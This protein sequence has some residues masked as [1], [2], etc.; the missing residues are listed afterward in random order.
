MPGAKDTDVPSAH[1][2]MVNKRLMS[3]D[4]QHCAQYWTLGSSWG[5]SGVLTPLCPEAA[6]Q[7]CPLWLP[8]HERLQKSL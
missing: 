8:V 4:L 7:C 5:E 1:W 6:L 3:P 2:E